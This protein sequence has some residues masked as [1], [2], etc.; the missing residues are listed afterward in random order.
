MPLIMCVSAF[1]A[2]VS[3][4]G[5]PRA[6]IMMGR[7]RRDVAEQILGGCTVMLIIVAVILTAVLLLFGRPAVLFS[8]SWPWD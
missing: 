7:Q 2:L 5:A 8:Y 3:M 4:G 6:S 1:A